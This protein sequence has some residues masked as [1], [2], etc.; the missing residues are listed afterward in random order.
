MY[1]NIKACS[2][3]INATV[4]TMDLIFGGVRSFIVEDDLLDA[5][6]DRNMAMIK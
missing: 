1:I 6:K 3:R 4:P 5:L 2:S